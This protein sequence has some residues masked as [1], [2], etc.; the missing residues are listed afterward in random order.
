MHFKEYLNSYVQNP[1]MP[2]ERT[3]RKSRSHAFEEPR[4]KMRM[5]VSHKG[6]GKLD[7]T[8]ISTGKKS[9]VLNR[10]GYKE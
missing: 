7:T 4:Q 2:V 6:T 8:E 5:V 9:K 3:C 1:S 10:V